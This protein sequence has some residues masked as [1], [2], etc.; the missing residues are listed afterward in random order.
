[1]NDV[2]T[3]VE[4]TTKRNSKRKGPKQKEHLPYN[5][6]A[7]YILFLQY[8]PGTGA[9]YMHVANVVLCICHYNSEREN[10]TCHDR[11]D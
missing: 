7:T 6:S 2:C 1:M 10:I 11:S 4:N 3:S 5:L 9:F 8:S